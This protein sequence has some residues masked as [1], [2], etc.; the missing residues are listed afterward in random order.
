MSSENELF[1]LAEDILKEILSVADTVNSEDD[2]YPFRTIRIPLSQEVP[3]IDGIERGRIRLGYWVSAGDWC[4]YK[5]DDDDQ[6]WE[7]EVQLLTD[8][9]PQCFYR[10][11]KNRLEKFL[12]LSIVTD[13][14]GYKK[15][16]FD[17][18]SPDIR[19]S[20]LESYARY[21]IA[22]YFFR[23][24][25]KL[26]M[27]FFEN[28]NETHFLAWDCSRAM[29]EGVSGDA[30]LQV[31]YDRTEPLVDMKRLLAEGT[32]LRRRLLKEDIEAYSD[33]PDFVKLG[34]HY[35]DL[36]PVWQDAKTIYKQNSNRA[37]WRDLVRAAYPDIKFD[38]DLVSR[39]SG[40]LNDLTENVQ[41]KLS[42]KGGTSKPSSIALE[43]AARLCGAQPYQYSLR[44]LYN[45]KNG[46][47]RKPR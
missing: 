25:E 10:Q 21:A 19:G 27:T 18:L 37:T 17:T 45:I 23:L 40:K 41:A 9:I 39:L 38:D 4:E 13:S 34:R 32:V 7:A 43:H 14:R 24:K 31:T 1:E 16:L 22:T 30:G 20:L 11:C 26:E 5:W 6:C 12:S 42:E 33:L 47:G 2:S 36:L 8:Y 28:W 35:S 44:H 15:T 46:L 29:V 3:L